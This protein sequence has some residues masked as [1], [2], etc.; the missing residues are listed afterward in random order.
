MWPAFLLGVPNDIAPRCEHLISRLLRATQIFSFIADQWQVSSRLTASIGL[1]WELYTP[2]TPEHPGGFSNYIPSDNTLVIAG[3]GNNPSN[4]G[5]T[6]YKH[7]LA[8]RVGL[9]YRLTG[10][11][12]GTVLRTGFGLSYTPFPDNTYAYNYPVRSNNEYV[13]AGGNS[14]TGVFLP[15]GRLGTFANGFPAPYDVPIP[16]DGIIRNPDPTQSYVYIPKDYKNSYVIQWN[17][18]VQQSLPGHLVLDVAYVGSHGVNS[19]RTGQPQSWND[20]RRRFG[21]AAV[22]CQVREGG[23]RDPV[24]PG[25]LVQLPF[26]ARK[27]RPAFQYWPD[28][29][30]GFHLAEGDGLHRRR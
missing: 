28:V 12:Y 14:Y 20:P 9:A 21:R 8:P 27:V 23:G 25:L 5:M 18:A 15:D 30:H 1:R 11:K 4:L 29:D 13:T 26:A 22:L 6:F 2:M 24:L 10:G 16:S 19:P 17:F 3:V 7:Y